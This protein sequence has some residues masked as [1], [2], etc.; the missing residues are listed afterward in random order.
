MTDKDQQRIHSIRLSIIAAMALSAWVVVEKIQLAYGLGSILGSFSG[1]RLLNLLPALLIAIVAGAGLWLTYTQPVKVLAQTQAWAGRLSLLGLANPLIF[2]GLGI[3][4]PL[5]RFT[6]AFNPLLRLVD[7]FFIFGCFALLGSIFLLA[8]GWRGIQEKP[9]SPDQ[10]K[11]GR[12]AGLLTQCLVASLLLYGVIYQATLYIPDTGRESGIS[13]YPLTLNGYSE[14]SRYYY[15]SLFLSRSV[16]GIQT[17]LP[18]L[19]PSRYLLQ[20]IP[21]ILPNLP[22]WAHRLWQVLLW[23]GFTAAGSFLLTRRLRLADRLTAL[24][25]SA[26]VFLFFFQAPV[27]YH[28]MACAL[29]VLWGF[30]SQKVW[31]SILVVLAASIWAGISRINWYPVPGLLAVVLYLMEQPLKGKNLLQFAWKPAIWAGSGLAA[32]FAA[33]KV[34]V[35][36]SG[37]P[38]YVFGSSLTSSLLKYRLWPNPTYGPGIVW[39]LALTIFPL[40]LLILTIAIPR[41]ASIHWLRWAGIAGV[42]GVL[43]IGDLVVSIKI[44]GGSNLHNLDAFLLMLALVGGYGLFNR[45]E[46]DAPQRLTPFQPAWWLMGLVLAAPLIALVTPNVTLAVHPVQ[47]VNQ[48][49]TNLQSIIDQAPKDS[50]ILFISQRQLLTFH[51]L[52]GPALTP[53][54][55]MTF[56]MEMAMANNQRYFQSFEKDL[57]QHRFALIVTD[58]VGEHLQGDNSI[59]SEENN[60]YVTHVNHLLLTYYQPETVIQALNLQILVPR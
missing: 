29:L 12:W 5:L 46:A 2:A 26:W 1:S 19:H 31:R 14:A 40:S 36:V 7:Q 39:A 17:P 53:D 23:L 42:L 11:W 30:D 38:G 10:T 48:G 18:V 25:V 13:S 28:L 16:Y 50:A 21:F 32:A 9:D 6:Q 3:A 52:H 24:L 4:Y 56:L 20:A 47:A 44:G 54:Y 59:F 57:S 27:Y 60:A 49:L 35:A 55:E 33:N 45:I 51:K 43:L 58:P 22:I 41:L 15:A 37:N 34:Y 8:S